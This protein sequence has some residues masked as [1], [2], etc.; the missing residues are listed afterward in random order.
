[1]ATVN[2]DYITDDHS[3]QMIYNGYMASERLELG[4]WF[5]T[6]EPEANKGYIFTNHPNIEK[7]LNATESDGHSGAS[8]AWMCR[9]LQAFYK[10]P[11]NFKANW[12]RNNE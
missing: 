7:L 4:D 9:N 6:W 1:M 3:R 12:T 11:V 8:F 5:K 10:D 2:F